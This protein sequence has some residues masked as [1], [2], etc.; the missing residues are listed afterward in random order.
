M[1]NDDDDDDDDNVT[2]KGTVLLT[3]NPVYF[4]LNLLKYRRDV[5]RP[6]CEQ[7]FDLT[8]VYI[9]IYIYMSRCVAYN[10]TVIGE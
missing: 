10:F 2:E 9:Y 3:W 6:S 1:P 4:H 7:R 5:L 8:I